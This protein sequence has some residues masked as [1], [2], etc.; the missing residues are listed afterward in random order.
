MRRRGSY[1][2]ELA[3]LLASSSDMSEAIPPGLVLITIGSVANVSITALFTGGLLPAAVAAVALLLMSW[4][5]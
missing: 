3:A 2:G 5:R 1:P 4:Y